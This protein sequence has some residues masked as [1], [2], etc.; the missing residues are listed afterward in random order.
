MEKRHS[1]LA[2]AMHRG[3][4]S[5]C[6]KCET[7]AAASLESHRIVTDSQLTHMND[8]DNDVS[9]SPGP[10]TLAALVGGSRRLYTQ[11]HSARRTAVVGEGYRRLTGSG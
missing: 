3:R 4:P 10:V 2:R 7:E 6:G 11:P 9:S 8:F 1:H 5:S